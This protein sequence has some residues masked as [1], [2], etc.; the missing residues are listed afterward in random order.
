MKEEIFHHARLISKD[1]LETA[2]QEYIRWY[3]NER[4]LQ[5]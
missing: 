2:L 5:S 1:A 3:N 4:S